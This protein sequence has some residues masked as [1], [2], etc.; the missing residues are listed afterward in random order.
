MLV[1]AAPSA[2][3]GRIGGRSKAP[4][5]KALY[6]KRIKPLGPAAVALL[7]DL[8]PEMVDMTLHHVMFMFQRPTH[9]GIR[10][11]VTMPDG[12]TVPDLNA[13]SDGLA[14]DLVAWIPAFSK[15]RHKPFPGMEADASTSAPTR[16]KTCPRSSTKRTF[17]KKV[18]SRV[19]RPG[20]ARK[21]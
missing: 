16:R 5:D 7:K 15:E 10:I 14:G 4:A 21:R 18:T 3:R 19:G 17:T 20:A 13:A 9:H 2:L 8:I 12:T 1:R 6:R 11:S